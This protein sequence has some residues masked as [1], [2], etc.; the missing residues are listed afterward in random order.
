MGPTRRSFLEQVG[1][2]VIL[3]SV[4]PTLACDLGLAS[5]RAADGP[6]RLNFGKREALV[7]L[8]QETPAG[9]MLPLVVDRLQKGTDLKE[10]VAAA[11]LANTRNFGG[12]DYVGF[13]TMMALGPSYAMARELPKDRQALP[14]LKVLYRNSARIAARGGKEVLT[15]VEPATIDKSRGGGELLRD[16]VRRGTV[17]DAE[18]TFAALAQGTPDD[19][20]NHLLYTVEDETEVHRVVLAYR[21][22]DMID[23]VGKDQAHTL[24]RQSVR[25][26]VQNEKWSS[27]QRGL[28]NCRTV[29]PKMLD[30][31]KLLGKSAGKRRLDD[32]ALARL[33]QD[34]F[35]AT[36]EQAA[37][38]AA[39]ALADG[40][41]PDDVAE[42]ITLATCELLLR[43]EGRPQRQT[44]PGKPVGSVHGDSIGVHACDSANAW[45]NL[46]RVSNWRNTAACLVL[47][48]FQAALDR[49]ERG[50]DFLRWETYPRKDHQEKVTARDA[51]ALLRDAEGAIKERDQARA[52]AAV[53][54]Y[55]QLGHPD[56]AVFALL[57]KYAISEDGALH[58]EKFYKTAR[59]EH[60]RT[61]TAYRNRF[62]V[63]LA[64]VTASAYG[65][66]APGHSESCKL[67]GV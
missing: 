66:P 39:E 62:V 13:H 42:A 29:L 67:L 46:A 36:P 35:K 16:T 58:A 21:A 56:R 60:G 50:G 28:R 24:L 65:Q 34:I 57:L 7:Q 63:G 2:G 20:L 40:I 52:A 30:R 12:E 3:A 61:R 17:K 18:Q 37:G 47:G 64:R 43:D 11:A 59:E 45:R 25:Y 23:L 22:W 6:T 49:A 8:L 44:S 1:Q 15:P 5:A 48:A 31:H 32:A 53:H 14:V 54:R 19:A 51:D 10:I 26:C 27:Q 41:V 9:K 4:G 55:L 33:S 38:L